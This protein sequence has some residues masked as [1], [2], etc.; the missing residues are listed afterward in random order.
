MADYASLQLYSWPTPNGQKVH[1]MLEE[2]GLA[3]E[4][5]PIDIG[6]GAQFE[7]GF[8]RISPNNKIPALVDM[9]GPGGRELSI[10]ESGAILL[11]LAEKTGR[12]LSAE[13]V[14]RSWTLQWLFFQV[15]SVGPMLGQA[16]HFRVYSDEKVPYAVERYTNEANRIYRVMDEHL[17][18]QPWFGG[19]DYSIAD[20]AIY[21]WTLSHEKQGVDIDDYPNVREWQ[22]QLGLREG[23]Q[24]GMEVLAEH[25]RELTREDREVLFGQRQARRL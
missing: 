14:P 24:R 2:C 13:P 19:P 11:Y 16:H 5:H 12:F 17:E 1:I 20:M 6:R 4:V 25:K 9:D 7:A 10:F 15:G 23:V 21:P 18:R 3:Y 22:K 8:L